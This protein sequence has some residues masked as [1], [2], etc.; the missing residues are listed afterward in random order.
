MIL[1]HT[2]YFQRWLEK[3]ESEAIENLTRSTDEPA[4][5][6]PKLDLSSLPAQIEL[7]EKGRNTFCSEMRQ[8]ARDVVMGTEYMKQLLV[9]WHEGG[10]FVD[11]HSVF[12]AI[13]QGES[14]MEKLSELEQ[15]MNQLLLE[16][17]KD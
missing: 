5:D 12:A 8:S 16:V 17:T 1:Q 6:P 4:V 7:T 14:A 9:A 15:E 11:A 10:S 2:D 13:K 3:H